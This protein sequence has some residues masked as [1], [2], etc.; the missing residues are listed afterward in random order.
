M[1]DGSLKNL[2]EVIAHYNNGGKNHDQQNPLIRPLNLTKEE[3][4]DL[5]N[6]LKILTDN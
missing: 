1:F 6:F 4:L 2:E 3:Q 5:I